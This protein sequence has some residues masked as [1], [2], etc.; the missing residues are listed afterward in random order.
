MITLQVSLQ[1]YHN[2][3]MCRLLHMVPNPEVKVTSEVNNNLNWCWHLCKGADE[4]HAWLSKKWLMYGC[5]RGNVL[6]TVTHGSVTYIHCHINVRMR[7][8][9][10]G[11]VASIRGTRHMSQVGIRLWAFWT[12][13]NSCRVALRLHQWLFILVDF[14]W[15]PTVD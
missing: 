5:T 11:F 13:C 12:S 2:Y 9:G 8:T 10:D 3:L 7:S 1:R 14:D 15:N 4:T 6:L